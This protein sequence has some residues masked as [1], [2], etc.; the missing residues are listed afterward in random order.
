VSDETQ[1]ER[2]M[3]AQIEGPA[4]RPPVTP[5]VQSENLNVL[6]PRRTAPQWRPDDPVT[7]VEDMKERLQSGNDKTDRR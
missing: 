1:H 4:A 3:P 6:A 2:S 7:I 5:K